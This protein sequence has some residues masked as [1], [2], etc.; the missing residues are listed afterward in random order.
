M[1][2]IFHLEISDLQILE[3]E[4]IQL[5]QMEGQWFWYI[6]WLI[7]LRINK[8]ESLNSSIL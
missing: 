1:D 4:I 7:S 6:L 3:W 8:P 5:S 2:F